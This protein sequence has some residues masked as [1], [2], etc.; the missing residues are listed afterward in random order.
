MSE[1]WNKEL[2]EL[3]KPLKNIH[4]TDMELRRWKRTAFNEQKSIAFVSRPLFRRSL[5]FAAAGCVGFF[6][7]WTVFGSGLMIRS[8]G[9]SLIA[10]LNN[11]A[12]VEV[13]FSN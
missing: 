13:I 9:E 3:L 7:G 11:N 6:I 8:T 5:Q 1:D 12:T 4:P 2:E 10:E